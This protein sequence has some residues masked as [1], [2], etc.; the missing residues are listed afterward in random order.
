VLTVGV[1]EFPEAEITRQA[2]HEK[3]DVGDDD[4]RLKEQEPADR[5][6]CIIE[7]QPA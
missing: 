2:D 1:R 3:N 4:E 5:D 6:V 7:V